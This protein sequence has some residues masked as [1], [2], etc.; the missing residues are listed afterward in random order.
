MKKKKTTNV[1]VWEREKDAKR[2]GGREGE[3]EKCVKKEC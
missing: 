1:E 3:R 2:R